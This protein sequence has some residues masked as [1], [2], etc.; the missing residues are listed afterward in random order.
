MISHTLEQTLVRAISLARSCSHEYATLEHLLHALI[1]D[2]DASAVLRACGV[3]LEDL[4]EHIEATLANFEDIRGEF[5]PTPTMAFQRTIQRALQHMRDAGKEVT[6]GAHVLI[7]I[8]DETQSPALYML[9]KQGF[10][11]LDA[12]NFLSHGVRKTATGPFREQAYTEDLPEEEEGA[13]SNNPLE[14]YCQNLSAAAQAGQLDPLIGRTVELERMVQVLVRRHKNNPLLVGEPGVGKT[15]LV[16]GLAH[17]LLHQA[18]AALR[19]SEV[20][21]LDM[22]ALLAGTRYRGDFEE[23][24]KA[25]L[26]ALAAHP[27]AILAIDEIHTIVGAGAVSGG[28]MDASNLLKPA[29]NGA[30]RCIGATTYSEYK[31]LERDRALARR[32]QKIDIPEPTP[33]EALE[34]AAGLLPQYQSYHQLSYPS[35]TLKVAVDLSVRYLPDRRLPDKAIDI[36]DEVGARLSLREPRPSV[37][38]VADV[39]A[40]VAHMA[41]VQLG[42]VSTNDSDRLR[43][44]EPALRSSVFGQN[45]AIDTVVSAVKLARA[46]LREPQKPMG[47]FL[48][49]GP[50]GVGKT[51]LARQ[52]AQQLG[53]ELL[54]F[55]MSEYMEQHAVAR[56]IGAPPGYVGFE[57]GG[58]LTDAVHKHP[59]AVL[60][61]DEIE[62]AHPDVYNLLLQV[63]DYGKLTDHN[64]RTVDF[65]SV[66]LIMTSNVG[67]TELSQTRL[68]FSR[69]AAA[70]QGADREAIERQFTPEFRNRLD[71]IV[72][73]QALQPAIMVQVVDKLLSELNA[74]LQD[75]AIQLTLSPEARQWLADTGYQPA[76][77]ARPL[78]RVI[79]EHLKKP[80]AELMLFGALQQ[81]GKVRVERLGEGVQLCL[82]AEPVV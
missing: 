36:L 7:S 39:E 9:Q 30:L 35:E 4:G 34:I 33:A 71:S 75:K 23:R 68:G 52:L 46:G 49:T 19:G 67:A 47:S 43:Q 65:R 61:L 50:T 60:L 80:L 28:S 48:F 79:Q 5:E 66:I 32:F 45:A 59:Q 26:S 15:A 13:T 6:T 42:A 14:S 54:R 72:R 17:W 27:K 82:Q 63:M 69:E 76:Y 55:D 74:Q 78:A 64:G 3:H 24:M 1:D 77:G 57:Q 73:F 41:R 37:V 51:E 44:L 12:L 31:V 11:R 38:T 25:V 70:D 53:S 16:A 10:T 29:L 22:G 58:L 8:C 20:F 56:L 40:V 18:P 2:P 21:M 81:G 62:K